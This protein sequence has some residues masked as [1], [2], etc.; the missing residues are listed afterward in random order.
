MWFLQQLDPACPVYNTYRIWRVRGALNVADLRKAFETIVERHEVLRGVI[1]VIDGKAYQVTNEEGTFQFPC[2]DLRES[3][4]RDPE[5]A[6]REISRQEAKA[7]FDLS[8]GPLFRAK[9]LQLD[10]EEH[11]LLISVHHIITDGWSFG[12]LYREISTLY[13]AF[14]GGDSSPL[15]D[16][17]IQYGDYAIWQHDFIRGPH[18]EEL[19]TYWKR[20]LSHLSPLQ[21]PTDRIRSSMPTYKGEREGFSIGRALTAEL[22]SRYQKE[23]VTLFTALL[24]CF[25]V[26]LFRYT[27]QADI[28]VG[29]VK[30]NR[31]YKEIE[32][33]IGMFM[34]TLVL[35]SDL[36][37][38]PS[39]RELLQ[40]VRKTCKDAFAHQELPFD[41]LVDVLQ[42]EREMSRNPLFQVAISYQNT[43]GNLLELPGL[44]VSPFEASDIGPYQSGNDTAK[45]D[46]T[47][48]LLESDD[49]IQGMMEYSTDLFD[50]ATIRRMVDHFQTLI[51]EVVANPDQRISEIPLLRDNERREMM[52]MGS[53]PKRAYPED[54][55]FQQLFAQQVAQRPQA[56][57]VVFENESVSYRKL[58]T[59]AN[60]LAHYLQRQGIGPDIRVGLCL[61][62]SIEM[63]VAVLGI[64]K[65]GGAYVPLDPNYPQERLAFLAKDADLQVILTQEKFQEHLSPL[66]VEQIFLDADWPVI[67]QEE[68]STPASEARADSLAYVIYT[69]GST[70]RPKGVEVEHRQVLNYVDG[71]L[72]RLKVPAGSSFAMVS[73]LTA[74]L[75]NTMLYPALATGGTLHIISE[76]RA[77]DA[78]ALGAYFQ[79]YRP[80][81]LK[82]VP[83]HLATLLMDTTVAD[84][85]PKKYLV[86]G[87]EAC[88]WDLVEKVQALKPDCI[89]INHYG[90]TETTIGVTTH[91]VAATD[92]A[93]S[94]SPSVP[95]GRPLPNSQVYIL[96]PHKNP[97]P[98]GVAGEVYIGG[99][100]LA[101]G[102]AGA[103]ELTAEKFVA[104][105]YSE[106]PGARLY[107]TGDRARF[108]TD[109]AI[110]FLG[111]IDHQ[112]KLRGFR[113]ELGEIETV[114]NRHPRVHAAVVVVRERE[115]VEKQ[116]LAY[117]VPG[118]GQ[119]SSGDLRQFLKQSLP[120]YM[121]PTVFVMLEDLPL[122]P[123]GKVDRRH[124]PEPD[125][126]LT[127]L[128]ENFVPPRNPMEATLAEIWQSLLQVEQVG[129]HDNFFELGGHSL[130]ATRV[131]SRIQQDFHVDLQLRRF[132]N[133]PTIAELA[134]GLEGLLWINAGR[135]GE[136]DAESQ[137]REEGGI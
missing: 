25:N 103:P 69:S 112:V 51:E 127:E 76:D 129:V 99:R 21:L 22:K 59:R 93:S 40:R 135:P 18:Q 46:L 67:A 98:L 41:R 42:P 65:A 12:V 34:N 57:A 14:D 114:L 113:I 56:V 60:Q 23:G 72:E 5:T 107:R 89:V 106:E 118:H 49:D 10:D 130:L 102:Y 32:P 109:G 80:D 77:M 16:L 45:L 48:T 62:R 28:T 126:S 50:R 117:V 6:A 54:Q 94:Y 15:P 90:P 136:D 33:L 24:T 101:R 120:D 92:R 53:G 111:R 64:F 38:N 26:L 39:F 84:V 123:N 63:I 128:T 122:T 58:D 87:G 9:L 37:A 95:I 3:A 47:L 137:E 134:G 131:V 121:V 31:L 97:V 29:T 104:H 43:P 61:D 85:L 71:I 91:Q 83:S 74:D 132:L 35:R 13:Q 125:S 96:D 88:S 36:S 27:G 8:R 100:G 17:P 78:A 79:H 7:P 119:L 2:I 105:P 44:A 75:G 68:A 81:Y 115:G 110:E 55:C 73:P 19:L 108:R 70:G 86:V 11:V 124:L 1:Q 66:G 82:I 30:H 20:Q 52:L 133:M 116:L 4:S